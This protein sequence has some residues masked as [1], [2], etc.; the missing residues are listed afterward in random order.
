MKTGPTKILV[1]DDSALYR[2][3]IHNVLRE[4]GDVAIVGVAKNGADALEKIQQLAPDL[5]TLDLQMPDMDGIQVLQEIKGRRL[6]TKAIMVSSYTSEGAQLTTDALMEGAFDFILKPSSNDSAANRQ[7]LR[8]TLGEKI[9][10][11]R[12]SAGR[13]SVT[14]RRSLDKTLGETGGTGEVPTDDQAA[15]QA[16]I[17]GLST[18]GPEALRD[19]LPKLPMGLTV[20]VLVVQHMPANYTHSLAVRLNQLCELEV[21]EA[22]DNL[23]AVAGKVFIAAGGKQLKLQRRDDRLLLRLTDDPPENGVRPAVDYL[24]RS[25]AEVIEGRTLAVIMTGMGRDGLAGCTC[26]KQAGG[27]VFAQHED[28][29]VVYGMPKAVIEEGLAD[30]V[31][32]LGRIPAAIVRHVKSRHRA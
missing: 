15:C 6:P 22:T 27:Y 4:N 10:A 28:D 3:L 20:P 23:E 8:D 16:V 13:R 26:L 19:T 12:Q 1:V 18:G 30:R 2:Q 17:I 5:L 11:F 32:P 9:A 25:A 29:C 7:Q 21:V 31:V 14:I 24:L